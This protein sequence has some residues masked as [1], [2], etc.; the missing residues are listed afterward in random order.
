MP[1]L[2]R[3]SLYSFTGY[4]FLYSWFLAKTKMILSLYVSLHFIRKLYD[5]Y[6]FVS[7]FFSQYNDF[8]IHSYCV[9]H[10]FFF[11]STYYLTIR[12]HH[13]V[14]FIHPLMNIWIIFCLWSPEKKNGYPLQYSCLGNPMDRGAW[15]NTIHG[16]IKSQISLSS[17]LLFKRLMWIRPLWIFMQNSLCRQM[18]LF[19]LNKYLHVKLF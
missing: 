9:I 2:R 18:S 19:L 14:L 1:L 16:V 5:I 12:R 3:D 8:N 11:I 7:D 4:T 6:A 10:S 17:L 15:W 13:T